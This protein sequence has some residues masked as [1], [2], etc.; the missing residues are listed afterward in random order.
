MGAISAAWA[1]FRASKLFR[2]GA[3]VVGAL[4]AFWVALARAR[5]EGAKDAR[6]DA[7]MEDY[8]RAES[9]DRRVSRGRADSLHD[10]SDR[11]F[12]D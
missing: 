12:R 2:W 7:A 4:F 10:Y 3:L 8:K 6:R 11:G 1:L 5:R 9:I